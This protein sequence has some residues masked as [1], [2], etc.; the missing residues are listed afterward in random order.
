M[1]LWRGYLDIKDYE[2][3]KKLLDNASK[4]KRLVH[5]SLFWVK[6]TC[7]QPEFQEYRRSVAYVLSEIYDRIEKPISDVHSKLDPLKENPSEDNKTLAR[8][9]S[10]PAY[11][12][13][14]PA[15]LERLYHIHLEDGTQ[16]GLTIHVRKPA[17]SPDGDDWY[18]IWQVASDID[19]VQKKSFGV[20][21]VDAFNCAIN[22]IYQRVEDK[23]GQYKITWQGGEGLGLSRSSA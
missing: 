10:I 1:H 4:A 16:K 9:D 19:F 11:D 15:M 13:N 7:S 20:D 8:E 12:E 23:L 2:L 22:S 14:A 6:D 5:E 17:K 18:C 21:A 3:S